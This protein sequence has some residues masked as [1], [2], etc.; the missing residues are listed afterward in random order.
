ML[1]HMNVKKIGMNF[2]T[3]CIGVFHIFITL[4][5]DCVNR[6][7]LLFCVSLYDSN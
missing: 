4:D 7:N 1:G 5:M 3:Q 2:V 6:L